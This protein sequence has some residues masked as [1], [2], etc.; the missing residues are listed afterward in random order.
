MFN[1][2]LVAIDG[3]EASLQAF[4]QAVALASATTARL[5]L[6]HVLSPFDEVYPS[7]VFPGVDSIYT[8]IH[9]EA[10]KV[11][12][13]QWQSYE[14][15][16]LELLRS[17]TAIATKAGVITEFSQTVGNP[18]HTIC[19]VAR[20]WEADLIMMGRRGLTGL[21]EWLI[22]SVSNYVLHHAL[23]SVLAVQRPSKLSDRS[24]APAVKVEAH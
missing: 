15:R 7:P 20:T 2:I 5:M 23:C 22:G 3:S 8:G 1:Q 13:K 18:G 17:Q 11:Y 19:E 12:L 14:Q 10:V 6:L 4:E 16:G 24:M 21:N 9:T